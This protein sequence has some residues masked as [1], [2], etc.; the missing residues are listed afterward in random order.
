ML[1]VYYFQLSVGFFPPFWCV[2][3]LFYGMAKISYGRRLM[4][5]LSELKNMV[6]GFGVL[7]IG[8]YFVLVHAFIRGFLFSSDVVWIGRKNLFYRAC[9]LVFEQG[10]KHKLE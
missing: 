1:S 9:V 4:L 6:W 10:F 3:T 8:G 7:N 5:K 2:F